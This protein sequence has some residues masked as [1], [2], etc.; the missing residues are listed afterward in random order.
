MNDTRLVKKI[1]NSNQTQR[2]ALASTK[3]DVEGQLAGTLFLE[4]DIVLKRKL[5]KKKN[6]LNYMLK[7][8]FEI[9]KQ[10][11]ILNQITTTCK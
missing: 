7:N 8:Y 3:E 9:E 5:K 2:D 11:K 1:W 10:M 4:Q 6:I